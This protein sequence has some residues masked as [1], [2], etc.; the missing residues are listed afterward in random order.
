MKNVNLFNNRA[1]RYLFIFSIL[2]LFSACT[3]D[4]DSSDPIL[5]EFNEPIVLDCN[6]F[7]EARV[8]TNDPYAPVDYIVTC[9]MH[10]T[11]PIKIE[12]GVVI[13]FEEDAGL[14][15]DDFHTANGS[16]SAMGTS[17]E[18][19]IMRGTANNRG[20]W[21]GLMIDSN[22]T[23]NELNHTQIFDAGGKSFNSN[24]DK[25][26]IIV[27]ADSRLKM[28][29]SLVSN[30]DSYG[31]NATYTSSILTIE[32][33]KFTNNKAPAVVNPGY[34]NAMNNT[35][36]FSGNIDDFVY[37]DPYGEPI[38]TPTTWY[39]LDVP[40]SVIS[41]AVK[42]VIVR[43]LLTIQPGV[44][45]EFGAETSLLIHEDGG[46][47]KAVGTSA[48]PII[49]S[50]VSKVAKAW[51]GIYVSSEHAVNEIGHAEI[52]YSGLNAPQANIWLWYNSFLNVHNVKFMSFNGC[53][54]NYRLLTGQSSNPNLTIGD[55]VTA[56]NGCTTNIW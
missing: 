49:F 1:I 3:S 35:N 48:D 54:I 44:E 50:A 13:E 28:T 9:V 17:T 20:W 51:K 39:K 47:I 11:A 22:S 24:N 53:G 46:G 45:I 36:Q 41:N 43:D 5:E 4:D 14:E 18:P 25:G 40:Y 2:G 29:N 31:I 8:L 27:W 10:V 6:F 55:N 33:N 23:L 52:R 16:I 15:V 32:N 38:K 26:A 34:L 21:R 12:P 7:K 37:V 42:Q 19:I 56:D 30:S